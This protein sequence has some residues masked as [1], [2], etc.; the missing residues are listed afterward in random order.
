MPVGVAV[1]DA[2]VVSA[3][4]GRPSGTVTFL[5]TDI[6]GSTQLW[7]RQE[8]EMDAALARHDEIV[9]SVIARHGGYVF[10]TSGDAFAAVFERAGDAV[11]AVRD[12]REHLDETSWPTAAPVRV[13]MGLHTG[14]AHERD[15]NYFGPV[16]NR[17]ARIMAAGH[18]GQSLVSSTTAAIVDTGSLV[19]LGEHRLKDLGSVERLFQLDAP[20]G[21]FP[22]LCSLSVVRNNLPVPRA[23]LFGR[24]REVE[25]VLELLAVGRLV[26]LTG[27]GG[28]GKTRLAVA[29][30]AE[31]VDEFRDGVFFVDL[32]PVG[33]RD[34]LVG[35]I[36]QAVGLERGGQVEERLL[37]Y[38]AHR[39][40]LVILDNCEHVVDDVAD[41]VDRV[42][43]TE[44]R[45]Q[46][47]ATSR[48]DLEVD[49]ER[50]LRVASL[51]VE[52]AD[53]PGPAVELLLDRA[54]ALG[55][56]SGG[57]DDERD[58]LREICDRLDGI[59]LAIEL[60][61]AQLV[62]FS[63]GELL[64][65]LD[66]RF[67]LL[68]GGRRRRRQRQQTLQAVMD[69]SW[70]LLDDAEQALLARLAVLTGVWGLEEV[71]GICGDGDD[72]VATTLGSL[73]SK[74]LVQR[75]DD[76]ETARYRLLETVRLYA[77]QELVDRR[78]ADELRDRHLRWFVERA[79]GDDL[80]T[81]LLTME[82]L[83]WYGRSFENIRAAIDWAL[84]IG[85]LDAAATLVI[86][87]APQNFAGRPANGRELIGI[88]D[89]LLQATVDRSTRARL[90]VTQA[91]VAWAHD[92][93]RLV[94]HA[95][96]R[97]VEL[98]RRAD[99]PFA[100]VMALAF[101]TFYRDDR[102][103]W[104]A[105]LA[106]AR[107]AVATIGSPVAEDL[108][109][110]FL[111]GAHYEWADND[112]LAR[113]APRRVGRRDVRTLTDV[114]NLA[115]VMAAALSIGDL[116]LASWAETETRA[117]QRR[118][119]IP[120]TWGMSFDRALIAAFDADVDRARALLDTARDVEE[121]GRV[122]PARGELLLVPAVLADRRD[123]PFDCAV[124]LAVIRA[125]TVPMSG[126]HSVAIY[127]HLRRRT[128]DA[129]SEPELVAARDE[130][131]RITA[132]AA[133]AAFLSAR[134]GEPAT[135]R[136]GGARDPSRRSTSTS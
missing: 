38:L 128:R 105:N 77:Q 72:G 52:S 32:I 135:S 25:R 91:W 15:G 58:V 62:L 117:L 63:P 57:S 10:S 37:G 69:W 35:Q 80:A 75:L 83:S 123:R 70:E 28:V 11:A 27:V 61:A 131:E 104:E 115:T 119:G 101:A 60:A 54:D 26:T 19:D 88:A 120:E 81:H 6:E 114:A 22:P 133:L 112:R 13:R 92:D 130:A 78:E 129:L 99:D 64:A 111:D 127:R 40:V 85:D 102:E 71:Q 7:E 29:V 68:S 44:G 103:L 59:P 84:T 100:L 1:W 93:V 82:H 118:F 14:E 56:S 43:D 66:H 67:D 8:S 95:A 98:A 107:A 121:A 2:G 12:A 23:P 50:T 113:E 30:A 96:A 110:T 97:A 16:V 136:A 89:Q 9:R 65:R 74:S 48:E 126:G 86:A 90:L 18:G 24:E 116:E 51:A 125:N 17:A 33:S 53:A 106:E 124:L 34:Q 45:A 109:D 47:L 87:G 79:R 108:V 73:V 122:G 39:R 94:Q 31:A 76:A 3:E 21:R 42:L 36:A 20:A 49:G 134:P 41:V 4:G 5:F 55:V 46:L 132:D